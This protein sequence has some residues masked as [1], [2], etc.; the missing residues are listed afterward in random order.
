L[1]GKSKTAEAIDKLTKIAD[2][3]S[4]YEKSMV[5]YNLGIAYSS[6]NDFPNAAKAFAKSLATPGLPRAQREQVQYNLGQLYIVT[7]QFDEGIKV[8]QDYIANACGTVAPEAHIF[9]ANA[10]SERKRYKE[11]VPQIDMAIAKAKEPKDQWLQM[12]LAINYEL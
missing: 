12:K 1:L 9:L 4:D 3:G 8:L 10:L 2:K 6:K 11:A 7:N 5:N